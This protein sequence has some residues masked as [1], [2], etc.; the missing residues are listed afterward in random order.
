MTYQQMDSDLG[1]ACP[2]PV[3]LCVVGVNPGGSAISYKDI[4]SPSPPTEYAPTCALAHM[5]SAVVSFQGFLEEGG[6]DFVP[7][8]GCWS[9]S[10]RVPFEC[11]DFT[12][13][14]PCS[15]DIV[16][17]IIISYHQK[18]AQIPTWALVED[19]KAW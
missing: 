10:F 11:E 7:V 16:R 12:Q 17:R 9:C 8:K 2:P 3:S 5:L 18:N 14:K 1:L 15:V 6:D 13:A 4:H 19:Y